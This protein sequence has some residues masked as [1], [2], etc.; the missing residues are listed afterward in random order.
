MKVL[1]KLNQVQLNVEEVDLVVGQKVVV[2]VL[3]RLEV[4]AQVDHEAEVV[5]EVELRVLI[6]NVLKVLADLVI[7]DA[8][9][10]ELK[11]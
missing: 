11:K 9:K 3:R 5:V 7:E 6:K 4:L 8:M 10:M 2:E 1:K